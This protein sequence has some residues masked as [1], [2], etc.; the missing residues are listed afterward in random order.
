MHAWDGF[1]RLGWI[2]D[3]S[4]WKNTSLLWFTWFEFLRETTVG[5]IDIIEGSHW[6]GTGFRSQKVTKV[7]QIVKIREDSFSR[8]C[9]ILLEPLE[10]LYGPSRARYGPNMIF[11]VFWHLEITVRPCPLLWGTTSPSSDRIFRWFFVVS[12][13]EPFNFPENQK[14]WPNSKN[15]QTCSCSTAI[16]SPP[17]R[18][19]SQSIFI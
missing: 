19:F 6:F 1:G 13:L 3:H 9:V 12:K 4:E 10:P 2:G 18:P 11:S 7:S 14:L 17:Q 8:Q 15:S 5:S 16:P